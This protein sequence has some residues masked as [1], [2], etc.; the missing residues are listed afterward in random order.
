V[1]STVAAV[2]VETTQDPVPAPRGATLAR[3]TGPVVASGLTAR[4]AEVLALLRRRLTN[5]EIAA[6]LVVSVR[7]VE[8]H[9]SALLRK[10]GADDRRALARLA[11]PAGSPGPVVPAPTA[12]L[13]VPLT[14]FIGRA[15][16]LDA[17]GAAVARDRLVTATGPGG[18]GKTRLA[19][20]TAHGL[21]GGHRDG[22]VFVDL[23][24]VVDPALVAGAV[25][26]ALGV[27]ERVGEN[28]EQT[29]LAALARRDVLLVLDNCEHV[30]EGARPCVE[31]ILTRCPSVRILATSRIRLMLPYESVFV[32]PGLSLHDSDDG[33]DGDAL[34]LFTARMTAAGAAGPATDRER[35]TVRQICRALDGTALAIELAAARVPGLGLDGLAGALDA[36]LPLLSVRHRADDRHRSLRAAIDWSYALLADDEQA[37]LR[38]AAVFASRFDAEAVAAISGR[39]RADVLDALGRLADWSLVSVRAGT[40]TRYRVLETIRQY[41]AGLE[42]DGDEGAR[43]RAAHLAWTHDRLETLLRAARPGT[44]DEGWCREVDAVL[45][46]ARAALSWAG[47]DPGRHRAAGALAGTAAAVCFL[48]GRPGETQR[49]HEQAVGWADE[50]SERHRLLVLAATAAAIRNVGVDTVELLERAAATTDDPDQAAA[51]LANAAMYLLRCSGIMARPVLPEEPRDLLDRAR[52]TS[53]G[54]A[55]A[56]ATIAMAQGWGP[57]ASIRSPEQTARALAL[58]V[59]AGEPLLHCSVLDQVVVVAL[60]ERDL[61]AAVAA[62]RTRLALLRELPLDARTGFEHYDTTHMGS[63]IFLAAGDLPEARRHAAAVTAMPFFREERHIGLSRR[64]EVDTLA[65]DFAAVIAA[66]RL[67]ER[68]WTRAGRPVAGNLAAGAYCVS[69]AHAMLGDADGHRHWAEIAAELFDAPITGYGREAGWALTLEALVDLHS[70]DAVAALERLAPD[71]HGDDGYWANPNSA[72]WLPWYAALWAEAAVLAGRRDAADRLEPARRAARGNPIAEGII[73][74]SAAIAARDPARLPG[75]ARRFA[76]AGCPYQAARTAGLARTGGR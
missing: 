60:A 72:M 15:R 11:G 20:A 3:V 26:D 34:A 73:E 70:G 71:P 50:P 66:G 10:L 65:G 23:V 51:D 30:L 68:D 56:T 58:A 12:Q 7:T 17:L 59:A 5:N 63:R 29:L 31:Q 16:E 1:P 33:D 57:R 49:L 76:A 74:R 45:D 55:V 37:T 69:T 54:G 52:R 6:E 28:R 8:S 47:S 22:A 40:R 75:L 18:V 42:Q 9:V 25:A 19:L 13:P 39:P 41:A 61:A 46:D 53:R 24:K 27:S 44:D 67:M 36:H 14:P 62:T 64:V 38:A 32:V 48:R 43:L 2:P 35:A 4:E 21:A